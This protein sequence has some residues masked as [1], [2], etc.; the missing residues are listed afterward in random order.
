MGQEGLTR[1]SAADAKTM[2]TGDNSIFH[3][4]A[5]PRFAGRLFNDRPGASKIGNDRSMT[6]HDWISSTNSHKW[7]RKDEEPLRQT[8]AGQAD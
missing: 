2:E 8:A 4:R 3:V 5:T 6:R 1:R 7:R